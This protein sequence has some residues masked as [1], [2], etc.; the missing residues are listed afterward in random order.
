LQDRGEETIRYAAEKSLTLRDDSILV[1]GGERAFFNAA[2]A[3]R[4]WRRLPVILESEHYGGSRDRG[5][6]KD[7]SQYLQAIEEYHA[8][9]A[10]IH[11]WPREFQRENEN[12]IRRIN[13]RLGYRLQLVEASWP[14][15]VRAGE[16]FRFVSKWR[17]A[18]VAPC[19]PGGHVALT[20]KDA[21]GG[22]ADVFVD[23]QFDVRSLPVGPPGQAEPRQQ[24]T[25]FVL[26]L[27]F[28]L[29]PGECAVY[30]SVGTQTGT[31]RI[32]LPLA[33][34]DGHLRYRLGSVNVIK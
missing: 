8:S 22:I 17:N 23:R 10:S 30:V 28:G 13:M 21:K 2:M 5:N 16:P 12:L 20:L 6:W 15:E 7:G 14:R 25:T 26:S 32:A 4:F 24:E 9:Y 27:P 1:Q 33:D 19:L 34:N 31:P 3:E 18:G 11:W 29:N